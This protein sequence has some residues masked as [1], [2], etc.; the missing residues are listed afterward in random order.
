MHSETSQR[1][2]S[3]HHTTSSP[4]ASSAPTAY[5]RPAKGSG[6][7]SKLAWPVC[8]VTFTKQHLPTISTVIMALYPRYLAGRNGNVEQVMDICQANELHT[9]SELAREKMWSRIHLIPM[10]QAE[11]DRDLVRRT[12]A[13]KARERE[14]LGGETK[15]YH[16][17]RCVPGPL[18]E[19]GPGSRQSRDKGSFPTRHWGNDPP[20]SR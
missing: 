8:G 6:N 20:P 14:L 1:G 15:V 9:C 19:F 7:R 13:D 12:W 5:T 17:D 2:V 11:E 10:L 4:W 16:S 3:A 18:I